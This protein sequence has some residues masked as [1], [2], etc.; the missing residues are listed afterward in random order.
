M[1]DHQLWQGF[2]K[3][4]IPTVRL[5]P[6][7][8]AGLEVPSARQLICF[9]YRTA[10]FM[11][12]VH[13]RAKKPQLTQGPKAWRE[14][15]LHIARPVLTI[16]GLSRTWCNLCSHWTH[17]KWCKWRGWKENKFTC[18]LSI[19]HQ[20]PVWMVLLQMNIIWHPCS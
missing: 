4:N 16:N 20:F 17:C 3:T 1:T 7:H 15:S 10:V 11:G 9:S 18:L 5:P 8:F 14:R 13:S 6:S 2:G 19:L 12:L